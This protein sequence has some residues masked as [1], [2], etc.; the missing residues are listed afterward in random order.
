[1]DQAPELKKELG[2]AAHVEHYYRC[3]AEV[4]VK[5]IPK[6]AQEVAILTQLVD[7]TT[8]PDMSGVP[9]MTKPKMEELMQVAEGTKEY[10]SGM[11]IR[12]LDNIPKHLDVTKAKWCGSA[13]T[14]NAK[15]RLNFWVSATC[16][17]VHRAITGWDYRAK[18]LGVH[19]KNNGAADTAKA[20]GRPAE[21]VHTYYRLRPKGCAYN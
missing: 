19:R 10:E 6:D 8:N 13:N 9:G 14:R 1:M 5:Y 7:H 4:H 12:G 16:G 18:Q 3:N 11:E 21:K 2:Q 15:K 20:I 17:L